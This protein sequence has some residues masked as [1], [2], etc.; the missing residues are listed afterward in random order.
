[1]GFP[2]KNYM[3]KEEIETEL[4]RIDAEKLMMNTKEYWTSADYYRDRELFEQQMELRKMLK[5]EEICVQ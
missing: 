4:K 2:A 5:E 1:M 3:T